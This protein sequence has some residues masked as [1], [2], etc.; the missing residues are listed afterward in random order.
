[1]ER[2]L[3][4]SGRRILLSCSTAVIGW[5]V[6]V[7][8]PQP[9]LAQQTRAQAE[10]SDIPP[11]AVAAIV[12]HP[13]RI[14]TAPESELLPIEVIAAVCQK[15]WGFDPVQ[16]SQ[17]T[18]SIILPQQAE[19]GLGSEA[20]RLLLALR[21]SAPQDP[22]KILAQSRTSMKKDVLAGK[23]FY[24]E[25]YQETWALYQ[26]DPQTVYLGDPNLIREAVE[27]RGRTASGPVLQMLQE[28]Q[29]LSDFVA[30]VHLEPLAEMVPESL[31]QMMLPPPLSAACEIPPLVAS[32]RV[33]ANFTG[34]SKCRIMIF[35]KD[36]MSAERL[37]R[38]LEQLLRNAKQLMIERLEN[39]AAMDQ[40]DVVSPAMA[41]YIARVGNRIIA[42]I[43]PQ[44]K[45]NVLQWEFSTGDRAGL[46]FTA[47]MVSLLL[48]A[49]QS[50]REV[51]RRSQSENNLKMLALAMH[52]YHDVYGHFPP[53]AI[54]D[55][56]G[57]PFLSWR[58]ALLPFLECRSFY[59]Q[60]HLDEPWDS[61]HNSVFIKQMPEV[62]RNPSA[63]RV[64]GITHY[65]GIVGKGAFFEEGKTRK[66][67]DILDG[68]S[69]TIMFVEVDPDRGVIWT[70][71]EDLP[72]NPDN[73]LDGLGHAH[74]GGFNAAFAD[75]SV[76]FI[77]S[78]V[79][80]EV[81]RALITVAG[82]E[83]LGSLEN[84]AGKKRP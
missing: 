61:P 32:L 74:P 81:F 63:P 21:F 51:A 71:P 28:M 19:A 82:G 36:A 16:L 67:A 37:E 39:E 35:A 27:K 24:V 5:A 22:E 13:Q 7:L 70:K 68:T 6:A 57:K 72:F 54:T 40:D 56:N 9:S 33:Q 1:M 34:D 77:S 75:G 58:V 64:P 69:K 73:P 18:A 60:F 44:R 76:Y 2:S 47:T 52:N 50:A 80:P 15:E 14:L 29:P 31:L 83:A 42:G 23:P 11:S 38:I 3:S 8:L 46:G 43:M 79:D 25:R 59:D 41:K 65:L 62:F 17:M 10:L 49:V 78:T 4:Q 48:P 53:Q 55:K 26:V 66:L 12:V 84:A 20:P 45:D 30:V